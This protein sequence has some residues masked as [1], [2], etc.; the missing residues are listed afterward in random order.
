MKT[1]SLA[2]TAEPSAHPNSCVGAPAPL[3]AILQIAFEAAV[4]PNKFEIDEYTPQSRLDAIMEQ[5]YAEVERHSML[6]G[7]SERLLTLVTTVAE[8]VR[9]SIACFSP[10]I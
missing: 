3:V 8:R 10:L 7:E 6:P 1:K 4:L 2:V 9:G 5:A